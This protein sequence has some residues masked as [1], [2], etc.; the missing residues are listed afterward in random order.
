MIKKFINRLLGKGAAADVAP[1][2]AIT[3]GQRAEIPADQHRID[4]RLLDDNA[5][6]V[7]RTLKDAGYEGR[8]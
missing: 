2:P 1:A 7:V 5:V 6:R 8:D 3:L 4:P